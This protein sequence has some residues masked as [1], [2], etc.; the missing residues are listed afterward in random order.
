[1]TQFLVIRADLLE[2]I[3][4]EVGSACRQAASA[5]LNFFKNQRTGW[6]TLNL[7]Q[8]HDTLLKQWGKETVRRAAEVLADCGLIERKHHRMNGRAW[9][10]RATVTPTSV[11][12]APD[13]ATVTLS[14]V[15]SI[16]KDPL[17][18]PQQDPPVVEEFLK[19]D[20]EEI[21]Q[22]KI[23]IKSISINPDAVMR[24]V[25]KNFANFQGAIAL[26]K[27]A[28][29]D[30]SAKNPTG[31]LLWS[32]KSGIKADFPGGDSLEKSRLVISEKPPEIANWV[33]LN[34][35]DYFYS[36]LNNEWRVVLKNGVQKPW[37]E[38]KL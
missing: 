33:K 11:T 10:Y 12:T 25:L 24:E 9:Q 22:A 32:L 18:N 38:V 16:Y 27:K 3:P 37:S 26:T 4:N 5:L 6:L 8:L 28:I 21:E 14:D 19:I 17:E 7:T 13:T 35:K 15:T 23:E 29:A 34:G 30:G 2:L 20:S 31:L 36:S 1:M